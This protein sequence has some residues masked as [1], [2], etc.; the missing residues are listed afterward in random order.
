[1]RIY[2]WQVKILVPQ[3]KGIFGTHFLGLKNLKNGLGKGRDPEFSISDAKSLNWLLCD[4]QSL[5]LSKT[6]EIFKIGPKMRPGEKNSHLFLI[7]PTPLCNKKKAYTD[8]RI[9]LNDKLSPQSDIWSI[10]Q[11]DPCLARPKCD[12]WKTS[13]TII[14]ARVLNWKLLQ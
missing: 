5:E 6:I 8:L 4:A 9:H 3:R 10:L 1:M 11:S 7:L 2:P 13:I 12:N 14:T